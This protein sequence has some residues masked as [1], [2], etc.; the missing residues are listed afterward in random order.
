MQAILDEA[1]R[2]VVAN[3]GEHIYGYEEELL[4]QTVGNMLL[5]Q[6]LS[7]GTA[8]S[9]TGG[10]LAHLITSVAGSSAYFKGSIISYANEVKQ[11]LLGVKPETLQQFGAVSEQT[12]S[13]MLDGALTQLRT[14]I[15]IAI[16]GVAGPAGATPEKPVG[17]VF[18]GIGTKDKKV[19]KMMS[20]T[21]HRDRNIQLSAVLALVMLRKF[22]LNQLK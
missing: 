21:V 1:R 9:C 8:E 3:I 13:E 20:F 22:L 14:D 7:I 5:E 11:E 18:I 17:T 12:V 16:S 6:N 19:I 4:E 15:A 2:E 10:Y